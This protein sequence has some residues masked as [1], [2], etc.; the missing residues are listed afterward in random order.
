VFI[1]HLLLVNSKHEGKKGSIIIRYV[2]YTPRNPKE[3]KK[4]IN[5]TILVHG[6]IFLEK[7]R[8]RVR[9]RKG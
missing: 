7:E 6:I 4:D 8:K 2:H 9:K 1:H 5:K 3:S